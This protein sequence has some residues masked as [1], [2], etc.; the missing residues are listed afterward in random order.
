MEVV[1][2]D[3]AGVPHARLAQPLDPLALLCVGGAPRYMVHGAGA[4]ATGLRRRLLQR[5][6]TAPLGAPELPPLGVAGLG[7]HQPF[8]DS[9]RARAVMAVGAHP[10]KPVECELGGNLRMLGDQRLVAARVNDQ[11]VAEPFKVGKANAA[12]DALHLNALALKSFGP[13]RQCLP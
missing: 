1:T 13:E 5:D 11:L 7:T 6:P 9:D 3:D 4:L 12:V 8:Q 10:L 2:V